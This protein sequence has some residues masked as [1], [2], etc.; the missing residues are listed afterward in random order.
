MK[1]GGMLVTPSYNSSGNWSGPML[2]YPR[3]PGSLYAPAYTIE[4]TAPGHYTILRFARL[5]VA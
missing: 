1:F 5:I 2:G 4:N 3:L